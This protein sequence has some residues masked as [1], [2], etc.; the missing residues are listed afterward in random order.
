MNSCACNT[1]LKLYLP[2]E[3]TML[4]DSYAQD[5]L[6]SEISDGFLE[7]KSKVIFKHHACLIY[8]QYHRNLLFIVIDTPNVDIEFEPIDVSPSK[9]AEFL[10]TLNNK[11]VGEMLLNANRIGR[12]CMFRK[13][14]TIPV[15]SANNLRQALQN[16]GVKMN[17]VMKLHCL[18]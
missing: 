7:N 18:H 6:Q 5:L 10:L 11:K 3:L 4:V 2:F 13:L 17:K 14:S 9:V 8:C 1:T 15:T 16:L 12:Y